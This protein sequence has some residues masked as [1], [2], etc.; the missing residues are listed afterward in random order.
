MLILVLS[1]IF[2]SSRLLMYMNGCGVTVTESHL[3]LDTQ[4]SPCVSLKALPGMRGAGLPFPAP[5]DRPEPLI[6]ALVVPSAAEE[7]SQPVPD[8][9]VRLPSDC[10]SPGRNFHYGNGEVISCGGRACVLA[11]GACLPSFCF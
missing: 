5:R 10:C 1:F 6:V 2:K 7:V 8:Q 9:S 11:L 3:V 4:S